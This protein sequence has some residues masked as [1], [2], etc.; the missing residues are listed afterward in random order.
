ML[1][2]QP[3][4]KKKKKLDSMLGAGKWDILKYGSDKTKEYFIQ[5]CVSHVER[6]KKKLKL[7]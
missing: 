3:K 4:K 1:W 6:K 7:N 2:E 5:I